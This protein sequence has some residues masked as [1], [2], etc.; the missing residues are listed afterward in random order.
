MENN[1]QYIFDTNTGQTIFDSEQEANNLASASDE[2]NLVL[3]MTSEGIKRIYTLPSDMFYQTPYS[4]HNLP[5]RRYRVRNSITEYFRGTRNC[6][7][8]RALR[9]A[10]NA[11]K[12][13]L[14]RQKERNPSLT[15][16]RSGW[17]E[18]TRYVSNLGGGFGSSGRQCNGWVSTEVY[19]DY[20]LPDNINELFEK[21]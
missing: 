4:D 6:G 11:R 9:T 1:D 18:G 15:V 13:F 3:E 21:V 12:R 20:L 14:E 7:G 17:I 16:I 8:S 2:E 19:I 10:D 5:N